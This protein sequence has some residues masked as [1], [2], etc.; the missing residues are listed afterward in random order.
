M[1][2]IEQFNYHNCKKVL[3]PN[4]IAVIVSTTPSHLNKNA[5]AQHMACVPWLIITNKVSIQFFPQ[6]VNCSI[7]T[8][9]VQWL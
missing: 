7:I 8:F 5:R 6:S 3:P 2:H 4:I 9:M 1:Y